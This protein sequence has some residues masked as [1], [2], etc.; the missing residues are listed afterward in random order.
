MSN[1]NL[2]F[3]LSF[4]SKKDV[5]Q[6]IFGMVHRDNECHGFTT[7]NK[8]NSDKFIEF[9]DGIIPKWGFQIYNKCSVNIK[10]GFQFTRCLKKK[11]IL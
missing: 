1:L 5:R 8:F 7:R 3:L 9:I 4:E 11:K 10:L 6:N 2:N